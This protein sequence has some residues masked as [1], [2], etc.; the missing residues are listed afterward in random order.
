MVRSRSPAPLRG[1]SISPAMFN[2]GIEEHRIEGQTIRVYNL[3]RTVADSFRFRN[4]VGLDVALEALTEAWRT[5]RLNLEELN[6]IAKALRVQ[7][8]MQ[9]YLEAVVL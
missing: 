5:K 6:R 1:V 9:P 2:V 4:T 3:A 7:R 8:V